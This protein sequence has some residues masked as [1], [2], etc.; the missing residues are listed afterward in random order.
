MQSGFSRIVGP[1]NS[2]NE[3]HTARSRRLSTY[4]LVRFTLRGYSTTRYVQGL[5]RS[6]AVAGFEPPK[7][8]RFSGSNRVIQFLPSSRRYNS[9]SAKQSLGA[10]SI[11]ASVI[12]FP[13]HLDLADLADL[14]ALLVDAYDQA[15]RR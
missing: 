1:K 9:A 2:I 10:I 6:N 7:L 5:V 14:A 11:P 8:V 15:I 12:R 3:I 4:R 13:G